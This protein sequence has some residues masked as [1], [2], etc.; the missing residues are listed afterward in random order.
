MIPV[1]CLSFSFTAHRDVFILSH[2]VCGTREIFVELQIIREKVRETT[3][4]GQKQVLKTIMTI[5][6]LAELVNAT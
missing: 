5:L 2:N 4:N 6:A 3:Q 1:G